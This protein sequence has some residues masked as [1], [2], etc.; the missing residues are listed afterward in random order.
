MK[1]IFYV[2]LL[3]FIHSERDIVYYPILLCAVDFIRLVCGFVLLYVSG[4]A[5][6]RPRISIIKQQLHDGFVGFISLFYTVFNSHVP[7]ILLGLLL[8]TQAVSIYKVGNCIVKF[9][10]DIL[11]PFIEAWFPMVDMLHATNVGLWYAKV[12]KILCCNIV[13]TTSISVLCYIFSD[14]LVSIL[15]GYSHDSDYIHMASSVF[16]MCCFLPVIMST[17]WIIGMLFLKPSGHGVLYT[18]SLYISCTISVALNVIL[19]P[20]M[21]ISG[22]VYAMLCANFI[23]LVILLYYAYKKIDDDITLTE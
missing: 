7:S 16:R 1:M 21:T 10:S 17:C 2:L 3:L 4:I 11:D 19:I 23:E 9:T 13:M 14:L 18:T 8:N 22:P 12:K 6:C 20:K 5:F 15:C